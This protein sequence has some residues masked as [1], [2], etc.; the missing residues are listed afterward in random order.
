MGLILDTCVF[1]DTER[2]KKLS[3]FNLE[4]NDELVFMSSITAS[5]LL[6]GVH[7]ASTEERR[8]K[9]SAFVET[10]LSRIPILSF[11]QETAR[12]HAEIY[13]FLA[14]KG[15]LIGAH[16]L[17]IAATAITHGYA[18]LTRNVKEF[19]RVLGLKVLSY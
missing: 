12:I 18:L 11:T 7:L 3:H 14:K 10:I 19:K 15:K 1:I 16:D 6:V 5:E 17:I 2:N 9:R 8:L 13:G 4:E